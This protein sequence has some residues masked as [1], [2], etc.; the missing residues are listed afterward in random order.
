MLMALFGLLPVRRVMSVAYAPGDSARV[1][2][3]LAEASARGMR[4]YL[5]VG[6]KDQYF[7]RA[8]RFYET[9]KAAGMAVHLEVRP[10][11]GHELPNDFDRTLV[12]GLEFLVGRLGPG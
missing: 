12:A 9:A 2:A 8:R 6:E 1:R 10:G 7:D 4:L 3:A 11:L 5:V